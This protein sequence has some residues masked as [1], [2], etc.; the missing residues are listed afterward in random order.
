MRKNSKRIHTH[1]CAVCG[2]PVECDGTLEENH[3]G[4]PEVIC[5]SYHMENGD[6]RWLECEDCRD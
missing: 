6:I 1:P 5:L 3:D 4:F 2:K